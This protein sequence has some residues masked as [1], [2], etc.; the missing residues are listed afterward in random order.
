VLV[1]I[2]ALGLVGCPSGAALRAPSG[3]PALERRAQEEED[4]QLLQTEEEMEP[5]AQPDDGSFIP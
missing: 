4:G 5:E 2:V 1:P 3:D